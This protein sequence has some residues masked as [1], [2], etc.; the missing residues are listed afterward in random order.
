MI[1]EFT[2]W[3]KFFLLQ[4]EKINLYAKE[5]GFESEKVITLLSKLKEA[6]DTETPEI[7]EDATQKLIKED[8]E[9]LF[10]HATKKEAA[11]LFQ[12]ISNAYIMASEASDALKINV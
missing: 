2:E 11:V 10:V 8:R 4:V 7:I 5:F 6:I 3:K 12:M 9:F 1:E